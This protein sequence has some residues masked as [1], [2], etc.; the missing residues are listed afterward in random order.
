MTRILVVDDKEENRY[1]LD[2]LLTGTGFTVESA[3]H[4]AEALVKARRTL[5]DVVIS[6]LL[7]P[8]MDGY[9]LLR[10]WKTDARLREVPFIVYTATYT[11]PEDERLALDLGADA[12]IL[13]P[14]EPDDFLARLHEVLARASSSVPS[15]PKGSGGA[16]EGLLASYSR[17]LIR[18]LEEKT[19]QLEEANRALERDIAER[20]IVEAALRESEAE[21]RTLTDAVPHIV[22]VTRPDGA[23]IYLNQHWVDYTGRS[24]ED[25]AGDGWLEPFHPD[26]KDVVWRTWQKAVADAGIYSL[27]CRLRRADG[28]YRWWLV[29]GLPLRDGEG[30]ILKWLGTCT[31]IHDLKETQDQ[32]RRAQRLEVVGQLT[33][34]IAHDFNNILT[35]ILANVETLEEDDTLSPVLSARVGAIARAVQRATDLTRQLLAFSRKQPLRPQPTDINDLVS[36]TGKLLHRALGEQIEIESVLADDLW[37]VNVDRA[38]LEAAVVNLCVNARDAMPDGGQLRIETRNVKLDVDDVAGNP[39]ARA[40]D[41]ALLAVSDTG[42]GIAPEV[43]GKVFEPFFTTKA[44]GKGS[45]LGLSMVY[46][47]IRQSHGHVGIESEVGRGTTIKLHLPRAGGR[48]EADIAARAPAHPRGTERILVVEDDRQVRAG[49]VAQLKSL[50]YDVSEAADGVTGLAALSAAAPPVDLLLTDVVMPGGLN[51][52]ALAD[53]VIRRRPATRV[54]FMSGYTQDAIVHNG[55]LDPGVLLLVKPFRKADLALMVRQALDGPGG[56]KPAPL[57]P[58]SG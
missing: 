43:L 24:R 7:M 27:E 10:H 18:K 44:E 4:G 16:D 19:L 49:V 12:F 41:Y 46:G 51:G 1:Y 57:S 9:T 15:M 8:V 47:F 3:S 50:G 11:E 53:E 52:R 55:Q 23:N 30:K 38:Q 21:F 26:D 32:L 48:V 13:K 56:L 6:D 42:T 58:V 14:A 17:T 45:G 2:A 31:D 28:A 29:R 20:K 36:G 5:P 33:G 54:V 37:T 40:G 34:G 25:S 35:V 22:W 39:D